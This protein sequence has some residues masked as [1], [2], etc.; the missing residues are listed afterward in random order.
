VAKIKDG[1]IRSSGLVP[2]AFPTLAGACIGTPRYASPEQARGTSIDERTDIYSAG[3]VLY[4][5]LAGRGPFDQIKGLLPILRAQVG[6]DPL[7]PSGYAPSPIPR[8]LDQ[9]VLKAIS[10]RPEDRF[11]DAVS[12]SRALTLVVGRMCVSL[13]D[14]MA[15]KWDGPLGAPACWPA[16]DVDS[17]APTVLEPHASSPSGD[18]DSSVES[19][20]FV[21]VDVDFTLGAPAAEV[22]KVE[23]PLSPRTGDPLDAPMVPVSGFQVLLSAAAF[24]ALASW[25]SLWLVR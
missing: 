25:V 16:G 18:A 2:L 17:R 11:P 23:R 24:A 7:P 13:R 5:L 12:F 8:E 10:K 4:T 15:D 20:S 9:I 3:I 14:T 22:T 6:E 19:D 21:S 1:A